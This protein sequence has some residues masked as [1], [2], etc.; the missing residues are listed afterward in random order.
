MNSQDFKIIPINN[1][2]EI[3][4]RLNFLRGLFAILIVIGHCSMKFKKELLP[5]YIIHKFNMVGVCFFFFVSG[6]SLTYNFYHKQGYLKYFLRNKAVF[7]FVLSLISVGGGNLLKTVILG[8]Q[9]DWNVTLLTQFNWYVYEMIVFYIAF[10]LLYSMITV[11]H[12]RE[13]LMAVIT[14]GI[15]FITI[16]FCRYGTW[17]GWTQSYYTSSFSFLFGIVLGEHYDKIG[18][19]F[20][21]HGLIYSV[22]LLLVGMG[23]CVSL[24]LPDTNWGGALL[25]NLMGICVMALVTEFVVFISPQDIPILGRIISFLTKRSTEVYL[26]QFCLLSIVAELYARNNMEIDISYILVVVVSVCVLSSIMHYIDG[27]VGKL[28]KRR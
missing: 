21:R 15:C 13:I 20:C 8:T 16:Y 5:F 18:K 24:K 27:W 9:L 10:Y 12:Y 19:K 2:E 22:V 28:V 11:P 14:V 7:L 25:K 26:Y 23:C 1:L 6:L 3:M 17:S 4:H